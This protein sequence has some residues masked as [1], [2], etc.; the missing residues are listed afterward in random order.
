MFKVEL[1]NRILSYA[2]ETGSRHL[3]IDRN[4][5]NYKFFFKK[6]PKNYKNY[7]NKFIKSTKSS[8]ISF[9]KKLSTQINSNQI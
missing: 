3:C 5:E 6:N 8:N 7:L 1:F 9:W 4:W 2:I